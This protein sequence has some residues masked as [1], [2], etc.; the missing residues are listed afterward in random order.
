MSAVDWSDFSHCGMVL[1]PPGAGLISGTISGT[2]AV[3]SSAL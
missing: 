2:A 3:G 1:V